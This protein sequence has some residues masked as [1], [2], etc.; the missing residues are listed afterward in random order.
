MVDCGGEGGHAP[1]RGA[2]Q[3]IHMRRGDACDDCRGASP[4][5]DAFAVARVAGIMAAKKTGRPHSAVPSAGDHPCER[6]FR[7]RRDGIR[8]P[9]HSGDERRHGVVEME[10]LTAASGRA[11]PVRHVQGGRSGYDVDGLGLLLKEGGKS[12]G[13]SGKRPVDDDAARPG[14]VRIVQP[15]REED[16]LRKTRGDTGR[17]RLRSGFGGMPTPRLAPPGFFSAR[18]RNRSTRWWRRA[19]RR[20]RRLRR[21]TSPRSGIDLRSLPVRAAWSG[22]GVPRSSDQPNRQ[23]CHHEVRDLLQAGD[24]AHCPGGSLR[25]VRARARLR[26]RRSYRGSIR[27]ETDV[28]PDAGLGDPESR[29]KGGR[30]CRRMPEPAPGPSARSGPKPGPL[31]EFRASETSVRPDLA[32]RPLPGHDAVAGLVVD[33][34][35][36]VADLADLADLEL[37]GTPDPDQAADRQRERSIPDVVMFSAKSPGPTLSPSATILSIDS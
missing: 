5:G 9:R 31:D 30:G 6:R 19:Q 21:E 27:W 20:P 24:C 2:A 13:G 16:R 3:V 23:I 15:E 17:L 11:H 10:A 25:G 34:A 12:V 32:K 1:H 29:R 14:V 35:L 4:K 28:R 37:R 22:S 26:V 18:F 33:R 8:N 7:A 36:R